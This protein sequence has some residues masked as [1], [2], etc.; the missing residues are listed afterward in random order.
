ML[1]SQELGDD[2]VTFEVTSLNRSIVDALDKKLPF[3]Y[4]SKACIRLE[5]STL[6]IYF[7]SVNK[8]KYN[9][10]RSYSHIPT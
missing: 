7:R 10:P 9:L 3:L 1:Q 2:A 4:A 6:P 5:A 8:Y